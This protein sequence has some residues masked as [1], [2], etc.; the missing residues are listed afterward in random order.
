MNFAHLAT[1]RS[2]RSRVCLM[3]LSGS[4]LIVA[5]IV[6]CWVHGV[7]ARDMW[8]W[9]VWGYTGEGLYAGFATLFCIAAILIAY[10]VV[11]M[12][13]GFFVRTKIAIGPERLGIAK[14]SAKQGCLW[15]VCFWALGLVFVG[16]LFR[17]NASDFVAVV[18]FLFCTAGMAK[19]AE[20]LF[21]FALTK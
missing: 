7:R 2:A 12:A 14:A 16:A 21:V 15:F 6:A 18:A 20:S 5:H 3:L 13:W 19:T 11:A 4:L 1:H 17:E 8:R 9:F 10:V